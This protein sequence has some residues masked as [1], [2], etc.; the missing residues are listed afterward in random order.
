VGRT[1]EIHALTG[2]Q[3]SMP[4]IRVIEGMPGVG[5]TA[6]AVRAAR[7]AAQRYPDGSLYLSLHAHDPRHPPVDPSDALDQL[8]RML[9]VTAQGS[10][11]SAQQRAALWRAEIGRRRAVVV[12]DDASG[13]DQVRPLLPDAGSCLILITSR[14]RLRG[15]DDARRVAL[16]VLPD[17]DAV[18]L[19]CRIAGPG[20]ADNQDAVGRAVQLCGRLPL[21]IRL[22]AGQLRRSHA[23]ALAEL[24]EELASPWPD[25]ADRGPAVSRV[26]AAFELSYRGLTAEEQRFFRYLA[27]S[28]CTRLTEAAAAA[29]TGVTLARVRGCLDALLDHHLLEKD[30]PGRYRFHDLIRS[31]GADQARAEDPAPEQRRAARRLM[32]YHLLATDR[33]DRLLYPHRQ[34]PILPAGIRDLVLPAP[35]SSPEEATRWLDLEWRSV[36]QA[37]RYAAEHEWKEECADLTH[38]IAGFLNTGAYWHEAIAAH[39]LALQASR[40]LCDAARTARALLGLSLVSQQTGLHE[41]SIPQAEE[42]AAICRAL[43][44]HRGEAAATDRMGMAHYYSADFRE[45]LAYFEEAC[46]LY[47]TAGDMDGVATTLSHTGISCCYLGR[48]REAVSSFEAELA[49]NR[50]LADRQGEA[51]AL[52]NLA[53][54][55]LGQ[56]YHRDA[57]SNYQRAL[58]IFQEAGAAWSLAI[59]HSNIAKIHH[60]K[61]DYEKALT[62]HR[63]ALAIYRQSGDLRHHAGSLYD[64]GSAYQGL[65]LHGEALIHHQKA[66]EMATQ[67]SDRYVIVI[68]RR[69]IADAH[70]G[71]GRHAEAIG[72]YRAALALA[73]EI[74]DLHEEAQILRGTAEAV[75]HVKGPR[76]AR[77]ILR[78]SLDI[79]ERLGEPEAEAVRTRIFTLDDQQTGHRPSPDPGGSTGDTHRNGPAR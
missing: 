20:H 32:N 8:L 42:A 10:A 40:E 41:A 36:L 28:P 58:A 30:A 35:I 24:V 43:G 27:A 29:I 12:L 46:G 5:K 9:S 33:A 55:Q 54:I 31:F 79:F 66:L 51:G 2:E 56:G 6:L 38:A 61:G 44:D 63:K 74:G 59:L 77:I 15:L 26:M 17:S 4:L 76:E 47:R 71:A 57:L 49:L 65:D 25:P 75:L 50:Q 53:D 11:L 67:I 21:A 60:Y 23:P 73:R 68:A 45:A 7:D 52:N 19:F 14:R 64:I 22:T 72:V 48:Y 78:Q 69:G 34:R 18:T 16:G 37:A 13:P 1:A 3:A 62:E 70:R 39:A